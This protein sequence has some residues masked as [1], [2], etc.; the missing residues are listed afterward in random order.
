L[1]KKETESIPLGPAAGE[2][3]VYAVS[4]LLFLICGVWFPHRNFLLITK[5]I[6]QAGSIPE[7]ALRASEVVNILF[8]WQ[9][10]LIV[11][12][13]ALIIY[14]WWTSTWKK[15]MATSGTRFILI[16]IP[17]GLYFLMLWILLN[18]TLPLRVIKETM[19]K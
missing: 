18:L 17:I 10:V 2:T 7:V 5:R 12:F 9:G 13:L 1:T 16:C 3:I 6:G 4:L 15:S 14:F 19:V 8:R 11:L